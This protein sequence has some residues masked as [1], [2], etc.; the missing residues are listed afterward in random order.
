MDDDVQLAAETLPGPGSVT[1]R[2]FARAP[3]VLLAG[4]GLL[5][6]VAHPV[7]GAGVLE[8]SDFRRRPWTRAWRTHLS[9]LRFVYGMGEGAHAE[10]R[11]LI[12]VHKGIKGVDSAGRRYHA[13]DPHAYAWVHLTLARFMVDTAAL[14]GDPLT[15]PELA[16]MWREFRMIGLALGLKEQ[17]LAPDWAAASAHFDAVVRDTLEANESTRDVLEALT[18]PAKP[19]RFL[20]D[21]LWKLLTLPAG[22][23]LRLTTVGSLPPVLRQRMDLTWTE[24]DERSLA[25][26]ARVVRAVDRRLPEPLRYPPLAYG[27]IV[28]ERLR[29][30][31][32]V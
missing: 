14:F 3:G 28:R 25:R 27:V 30:R 20:P 6:Q 4:T 22:R 2:R 1:W 32:A 9:T 24:R 13:L 16:Q 17:H 21:P 18:A 8:H 11:R 23:V 19:S 29:R 7:V 5:L 12:E 10:G 31:R 26:L 15:E